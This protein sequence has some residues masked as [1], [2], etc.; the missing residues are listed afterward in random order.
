VTYKK[1]WDDGFGARGWKVDA[2]IGDPQI[3]ASTRETG[4]RIK[5]S[6]FVHDILDHFLSGYGVSGHRSEAMALIQL[7]RRT[8]LSPEPDYKQIVEEDLLNGQVNGESMR[9]FLPS[10]L[11]ALLPD[12]ENMK[13]K[14]IMAFLKN[15]LGVVAL[16]DTLVD[17]F[18]AL[19]KAGEE[20]AENNWMKLGLE[21]HEQKEIGDALQKLLVEIDGKAEEMNIEVTKGNITIDREN[22]SFDDLK[23]SNV[24]HIGAYQVAID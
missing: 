12:N 20:H 19:G 14:E 3:I 1:Y 7:S 8:G 6:V 2:T 17:H 21:H 16:T 23:D 13:D 4:Q 24:K 9:S 15:K 18:F 5:T 22:V 11:I 10:G